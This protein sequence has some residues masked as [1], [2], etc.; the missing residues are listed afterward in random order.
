MFGDLSVRGASLFH[1]D[2]RIV[3]GNVH[4]EYLDGRSGAYLD[5]RGNGVY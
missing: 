4:S 5:A 2:I 1:Q 3:G